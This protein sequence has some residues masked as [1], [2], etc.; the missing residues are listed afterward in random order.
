MTIPYNEALSVD[1]GT[2]IND[3]NTEYKQLHGGANIP[4]DPGMISV[5]SQR[6]AWD[7]YVGGLTW[8]QS[9]IQ[10]LN[11]YRDQ[12]QLPHVGPGPTPFSP[13]PRFW[14]GNMC[15]VR[16]A[17][18]P[19]VAGGANDPSLVL[20]WFYDRYSPSDRARIRSAWRARGITH[21][22]L[23]WPDSRSGNADIQ[24]A[25]AVVQFRLICQ[26]LIADGF[27]PC[28]MLSSK[29]F[30]PAD[31]NAIMNGLVPVLQELV[32]VV[33]MFCIGWE[34]SLWLS[35]TQVQQLIDMIAPMVQRQPGT[36]LYV[37]FQEGYPSFQQPGG[38]VADFWNPNVGKLTGLL[39]QKILS[40]NDAQFLDS[41]NDCLQ[42][43][44]GGFNMVKGFDF[45]ALELTAAH[46][47]NGSCSEAEGNR[48]GSLAISAQHVNGVGVNGSGNG[49]Q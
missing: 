32:G 6:A 11:E 33:P 22:L 4:Y 41:L 46:Q 23:S 20:S 47:F 38:T 1:F 29:D 2:G 15:G 26:E 30:D 31:V 5:M 40:Q 21:V 43:F 34:L 19:P 16:V 36:L 44:G 49:F 17:G 39:Y 10:H 8:A 48:I 13:A 24:I 27:F 3:A 45:V 18:L 25:V 42:R 37:H 14:K 7:Y 12:Y 35:P 28:V 9:R